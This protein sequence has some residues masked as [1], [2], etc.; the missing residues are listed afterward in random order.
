[1]VLEDYLTTENKLNYQGLYADMRAM[2]GFY[3]KE[4]RESLYKEI[5]D[6]YSIKLNGPIHELSEV[7]SNKELVTNPKSTPMDGQLTL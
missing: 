3:A 7:N 1:M 2:V 5:T 4:R 6:A